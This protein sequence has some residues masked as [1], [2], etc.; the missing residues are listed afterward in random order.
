MNIK[1]IQKIND[2]THENEISNF[3]SKVRKSEEF[4]IDS[5]KDLEED[6]RAYLESLSDA[7]QIAIFD[8]KHDLIKPRAIE[9]QLRDRFI[10][11]LKK[12]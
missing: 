10:S 3:D 7:N 5:P 9:R 1:E 8:S 6:Y 4:P 12:Q 2:I 11:D